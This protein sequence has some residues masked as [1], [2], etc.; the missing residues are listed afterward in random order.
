MRQSNFLPYDLSLKAK[1]L[2]YKQNVGE[3]LA[4]WEDTEKGVW[5]HFGV[6]PVGLLAAPTWDQMIDWFLE[7]HRWLVQV[8]YSSGAKEFFYVISEVSTKDHLGNGFTYTG[9]LTESFRQ[10]LVKGIEHAFKLIKK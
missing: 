5:F 3:S 6:Y 10:A 2:G 8:N 9:P 1:V 7:E 4:A